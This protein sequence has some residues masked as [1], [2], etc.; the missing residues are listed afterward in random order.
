[1]GAAAERARGIELGPIAESALLMGDECHDRVL[2][3]SALFTRA[4]LS[5]LWHL[6]IAPAKKQAIVD[7]LATGETADWTFESP[8]MAACKASLDA[9]HG[10]EGSSLV[11]A[12]AANGTQFGIRVS[13]L[14]DQW[15]VS[16]V[17]EFDAVLVEPYSH[18]D[19]GPPAGDSTIIDTCGMGG[20]AIAAAPAQVP[21][22]IASGRYEDALQL[23][24]RM[25]DVTIAEHDRFRIPLPELRGT[26]CGIDVERVL[27][28]GTQ[29]VVA[30]GVG[31]R[32]P[33]IGFIGY[34]IARAPMEC[35]EQ[36]AQQ[37]K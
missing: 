28:T 36:A 26:P 1:M 13:G 24:R 27:E 37:L 2:A 15:F 3:S 5:E 6:D 12:M 21:L 23:T 20:S 10:V 18:D 16:D 31:H 7:H 9:A 14:G 30:G 32:D 8:W 25:Y 17:P 22:Q 34:G 11:T 33:G 35:F 19:A 4:L 29:P